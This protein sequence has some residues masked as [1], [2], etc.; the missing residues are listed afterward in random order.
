MAQ[1]HP[2]A[3][4]IRIIGKGPRLSRPLTRDESFEATRMILRKEIDA[5]AHK[6]IVE[7][8]ANQI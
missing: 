6:D 1:E 8:V 5:E 7:A 3:Q 2:F 4:Y